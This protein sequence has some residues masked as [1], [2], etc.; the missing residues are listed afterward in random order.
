MITGERPLRY[1]LSKAI[2]AIVLTIVQLIILYGTSTL[3]FDTFSN[4][5][6]DFWLI[7]ALITLVFALVIGGLAACMTAIGL[8]FNI[9]DIF[10]FISLGVMVIYAF[11]GGTFSFI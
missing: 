10:G 4:K 6:M 3:F 2:S 5:G 11:F 1:L 9:D 7:L 8:H